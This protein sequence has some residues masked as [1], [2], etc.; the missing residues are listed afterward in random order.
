MKKC[1]RISGIFQKKVNREYK[2]QNIAKLFASQ[3]F[4]RVLCSYDITSKIEWDYLGQ[5]TQLDRILKIRLLS[6][7]FHVM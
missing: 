4:I 7:G 2:R 5:L 1:E 6:T 3:T